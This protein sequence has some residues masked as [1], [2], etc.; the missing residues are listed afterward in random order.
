MLTL[1][2]KDGIQDLT[3]S[4]M[5][6]RQYFYAPQALGSTLIYYYD[7]HVTHAFKNSRKETSTML[8]LAIESKGCKKSYDN[9]WTPP[10]STVM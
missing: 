4:T 5:H 3:N 6:Q 2:G 7:A 10:P 8:Y 9:S 1:N